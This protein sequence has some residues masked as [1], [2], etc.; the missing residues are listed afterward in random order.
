MDNE[1]L[2][3]AN[4]EQPELLKKKLLTALGK[5]GN[6]TRACKSIGV[7]RTTYYDWSHADPEGFGVEASKALELAR[8]QRIDLLEDAIMDQALG[9]KNADGSWDQ[10]PSIIGQIFSLKA[11]TRQSNRVW[12]DAPPP[13]PTKAIEDSES[14]NESSSAVQDLMRQFVL[15]VARQDQKSRSIEGEINTQ[16]K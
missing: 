9:T 1:S 16:D 5:T 10:K 12:S 2:T 13:E 11:L 3:P 15:D 6:I 14:I 4:L 7:G 8:E